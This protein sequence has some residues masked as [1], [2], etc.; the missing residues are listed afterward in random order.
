MEKLLKEANAVVVFFHRSLYWSCELKK[1][2]DAKTLLAAVVTRWNSN[3]I[4]LRRLGEEEMWKAVGEILSCARSTTGMRTASSSVPRFT[5][6][7]QQILDVVHILE[8]FE[9]ATNCLQGDGITISSVIPAL[10]GIDAVLSQLQT[11]FT[12]LQQHLR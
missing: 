2:T 8:P 12:S 10:I 1:V 7:R 6:T 5:V 4:K 9:E 11:N 3:L